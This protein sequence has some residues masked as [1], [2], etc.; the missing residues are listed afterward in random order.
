[1]SEDEDD[2]EGN[3]KKLHTPKGPAPLFKPVSHNGTLLTINM[4]EENFHNRA[5][6]GAQL[7][8]QPP[9]NVILT[10]IEKENLSADSPE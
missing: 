4:K 2:D 7:L 10:N 6:P 5:S 9:A 3:P 8:I 1:M